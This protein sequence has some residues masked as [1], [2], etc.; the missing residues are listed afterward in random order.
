[1]AVICSF[2]LI[3]NNK[4]SVLFLKDVLTDSSAKWKKLKFKVLFFKYTMYISKKYMNKSSCKYL[5]YEM[6][7]SWIL[8]T[9]S[10]KAAIFYNVPPFCVYQME[11]EEVQHDLEDSQS[12]DEDAPSRKKRRSWKGHRVD[13]EEGMYACDQCNK[14]FSK[15]SSLARHK[16]E[17]SGMK[18]AVIQLFSIV[19]FSCQGQKRQHVFVLSLP[20]VS[21]GLA[22]H[23]H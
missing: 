6:I 12:T 10:T 1:M 8:C 23:L 22:I 4:N 11:A 18:S 2:M 17:H 9:K 21:T 15:Q 20:S 19:F 5:P 7:T 14:L 16:Y 13:R 3:L